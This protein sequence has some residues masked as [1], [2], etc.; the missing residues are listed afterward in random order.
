MT[1]ERRSDLPISRVVKYVYEVDGARYEAIPATDEERRHLGVRSASNDCDGD[2][3]C[4]AGWRWMYEHELKTCN[5]FRT[6]EVC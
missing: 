1:L 2:Y 5:Y 6:N 3:V 4:W